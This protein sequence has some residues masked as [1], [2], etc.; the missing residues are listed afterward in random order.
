MHPVSLQPPSIGLVNPAILWSVVGIMADL[1]G[2]PRHQHPNSGS[3][4]IRL[5]VGAE[6]PGVQH[7]ADPVGRHSRRGK[8]CSQHPG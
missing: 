6:M 1:A 7:G 8:R 3:L 2:N 5:H 4:A